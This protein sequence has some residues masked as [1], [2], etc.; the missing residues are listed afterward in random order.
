MKI[1]LRD[2]TFGTVSIGRHTHLSTTPA[3]NEGNIK[4]VLTS[5]NTDPQTKQL[6]AQYLITRT[7]IPAPSAAVTAVNA[8]SATGDKESIPTAKATKTGIDGIVE[9]VADAT[10]KIVKPIAEAAPEVV[11]PIAENTK[12]AVITISENIEEGTT[13]FVDGFWLTIAIW[14]SIIIFIV[15]IVVVVIIFVKKQKLKK[16]NETLST[17]ETIENNNV[18]P[19]ETAE[20]TINNEN[21]L[22]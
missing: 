15:T 18:L 14:G 5:P 6:I 4:D 12:Q 21:I 9:N 11:K 22:N 17:K 1:H 7:Q 8:G 10:P 2:G 19:E 3:M 16:N 20:T 13:S